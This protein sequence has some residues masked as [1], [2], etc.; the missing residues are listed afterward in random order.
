MTIAAAPDLQSLRDQA[1]RLS[2]SQ[3]AEMASALLDSL[4]PPAAH[5]TAKEFQRA[6]VDRAEACHRGE[7]ESVSLE[8]SLQQAR[9]ILAGKRSS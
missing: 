7:L 8:E 4:R 5:H 1:L 9:D 3:R 2:E 6:V